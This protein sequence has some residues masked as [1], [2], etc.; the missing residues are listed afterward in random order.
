MGGDTGWTALIGNARCG[1]CDCG[2]VVSGVA[3]YPH[4]AVPGDLVLHIHPGDLNNGGEVVE[5][6]A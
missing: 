1:P 3:S 2:W 6:K 5:L 4:R